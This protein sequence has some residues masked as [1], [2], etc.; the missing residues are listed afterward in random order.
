MSHTVEMRR[1][2]LRL[3]RIPA[4]MLGAAAGARTLNTI[5]GREYP[6]DRA[7]LSRLGSIASTP[8][9]VIKITGKLAPMNMTTTLGVAP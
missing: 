9:M 1:E 5:A 7:L 8:C 6:S 2:R 3:V 4:A